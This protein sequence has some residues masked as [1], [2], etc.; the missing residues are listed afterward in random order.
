[1]RETGAE[2][3]ERD[4]ARKKLGEDEIRAIVRA[5]G[6]ERVLNTRHE[7]A[8]ARGWKERPPS[9]DELVRA[10]LDEPNL[11]RRPVIVRDGEALVGKDADAIRAFLA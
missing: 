1:V 3:T 2:V 6:V 5:A 10:A 7:V 4:Y 9:E 8:K 11:L